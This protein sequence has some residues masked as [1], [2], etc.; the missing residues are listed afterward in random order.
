M[1]SS[2]LARRVVYPLQERLLKRPTFSY[3]S[4]LEHSQWLSRQE[5][6]KLQETKLTELLR[7]AY[8]HCPWHRDRIQAEGIDPKERV[9]LKDLRRMPLMSKRDAA[10]HGNADSASL[11]TPYFA[12]R[13]R[14]S[15]TGRLN[16]QT[17]RTIDLAGRAYPPLAFAWRRHP[18]PE[19]V[20]HA[21]SLR[22]P[23]FAFAPSPAP[24]LPIGAPHL[25][26]K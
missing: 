4:E 15:S 2:V 17:H 14:H 10:A 7:A 18:G 11:G 26:T 1:I 13:S 8:A 22:H 12:P 19:L 24:A 6:E 25:P 16:R 23:V 9:T 21:R 20:G 5:I 3:L